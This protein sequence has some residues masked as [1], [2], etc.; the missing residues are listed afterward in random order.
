MD[1]A[2]V[3]AERLIAEAQGRGEFDNVA[4]SG[5][6]IADLDRS[7]PP[8]WWAARWIERERARDRDVDSPLRPSASVGP[9]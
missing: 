3:I 5:Q 2:E 6:P 9:T 4:G 1:I 7:R 8:G